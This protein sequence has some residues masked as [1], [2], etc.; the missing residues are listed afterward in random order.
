MEGIDPLLC[1]VCLSPTGEI[2]ALER[3]CHLLQLDS[4]G[5]VKYLKKVAGI[6]PK[7]CG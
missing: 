3:R 1:T 2:D 5:F 6:G 7:E 4:G